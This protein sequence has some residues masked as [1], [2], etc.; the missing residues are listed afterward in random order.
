VGL[1]SLHA[2]QLKHPYKRNP[3]PN[4]NSDWLPVIKVQVSHGSKTTT[5]FEVIVDSGSP[6]CFFHGDIARAIGIDDI[7][8]GQPVPIH[9]IVPGQQLTGHEHEIR[10]VVGADNFKIKA[11]FCNSLPLGGLLGRSCFFN[12]YKV[13]FDPSDPPGLE[14]T[15]P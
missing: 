12:R 9:G 14:F 1:A 7:T 3:L 5:P 11:V 8:S 15:K 10:L 4:N 6:G 2:L 13:T